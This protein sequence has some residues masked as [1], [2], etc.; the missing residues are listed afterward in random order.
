[1]QGIHEGKSNYNTPFDTDSALLRIDYCAT[2]CMSPIKSDFITP[3]IPIKK[4]VRGIGGTLKGIMTATMKISI[5][6][7]NGV[8]HDIIAPGSFY[9]P[10][11]P[12]R[13]LSPQHW[14]Q[15]AKDNYPKWHGT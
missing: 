6:D 14:A 13:L 7:D 5:E 4:K 2:A 9:V 10:N 11:C 12:S 15:N 8:P 1:M 3:L